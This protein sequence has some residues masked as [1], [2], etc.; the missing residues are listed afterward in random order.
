MTTNGGQEMG[1]IAITGASGFIGAGLMPQLAVEGHDVVRIS[2]RP[3]PVPPN[4]A[5]KDVICELDDAVT[6]AK[7]LEGVDTVVHLAGR[8][9][10]KII[11]LNE[12][13]A[14]TVNLARSVHEA[15]SDAGVQRMINISSIYARLAENDDPSGAFYG[16]AK[17]AAERELVARCSTIAGTLVVSLR[18]PLV[19]GPGVRANFEKLVKLVNSRMP[20]PFGDV[21]SRR[22]YLARSNMVSC[23]SAIASAP[24]ESWDRANG[25]T[26]ELCDGLGIT[27]RELCEAIAEASGTRVRMVPV[28]QALL[29]GAFSIVGRRDI[30]ASLFES[31]EVSNER[32][33]AA[34]GW[35]PPNAFPVTLAYLSGIHR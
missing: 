24:Q 27:L 28:R 22:S 8:A 4:F 33:F 29:T 6:L 23:L 11:D 18:P 34:F 5:G 31:L 15:A 7:S 19:Y 21:T 1:T 25:S 35:S 3:L 26:Y 9:H 20:L 13:V 14:S 17:L 30:A 12:H 16:I 10:R 32:I 2:R